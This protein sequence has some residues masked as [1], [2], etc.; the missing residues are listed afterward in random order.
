MTQPSRAPLAPRTLAP[1]LL[2]AASGWLAGCG[3]SGGSADPPVTP[4]PSV[5]LPAFS[6]PERVILAAVGEALAPQTPTATGTGSLDGFSLEGDLPAGVVF[7]SASGTFSGTPGDLAAP[8]SLRV[9][10][11]NADGSFT[12]ELSLAVSGPLRFAYSANLGD[13]TLSELWSEDGAGSLEHD[14]YTPQTPAEAAPGDVQAD[15]FGRL[16]YALNTFAITPY[17]VDPVTGDLTAGTPE[18][19]GSGPHSLYVH[20]S[21]DY[22][23]VASGAADRLRAYAVDASTG[24]L[25]LLE[26]ETT[27]VGP[28]DLAGDANGRFVIVGHETGEELKSYLIDASTGLL[29][30]A[31]SEALVT[32]ISPDIE[33]GPLGE[34]LYVVLSAPFEGVLRVNVDTATGALSLGP[35]TTAGSGPSR[36]VMAPDRRHAYVLNSGSADITYY[37]VAAENGKLTELGTLPST[38]TTVSLRF[39]K[40]G[41]VAAAVDPDEREARLYTREADGTLT[42]TGSVLLRELPQSLAF[43]EGASRVTRVMDTLYALNGDSDDITVFRVDAQLGTIDDGGLPTVPT[44][45]GPADLAIDPTGAWAFASNGSAQTVTVYAVQPNGDLVDNGTLLDLSSSNP[46]PAELVVDPSGR[47]LYVALE[48]FDILGMYAIQPDG[49]LALIGTRPIDVVPEA[50]VCDPAGLYLYVVQGGDGGAANGSFRQFAIDA[51]SG[52]LSLVSPD[53][54]AT[55]H[56]M[57]LEFTAGGARAYAAHRGIDLAVGWE[58]KA[59]GRMQ[60]IG[61]GSSTQNEPVDVAV[62]PDERFAFVAVEDS[63]AQGALL[64][65][66]VDPANGRLY[67][68]TTGQATWRN[69]IGAGLNPVA[70]EV[71]PDGR[72]LYSLGQTSEDVRVF[73]IDPDTA[74][75]AEVQVMSRGLRPLELRRRDQLQ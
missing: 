7:N 57:N 46:G 44:G 42:Q 69:A 6:Y 49:S 33:L 28:T 60:A 64:L 52:V 19:L 51:Q 18:S 38:A 63:S 61:A 71:S 45:A 13:N 3:S 37:E 55:G 66:D 62:T 2:L 9:T 8:R 59:N 15:P 23:Y 53:I 36:L 1:L 40:D 54:V 10:A 43:V 75:L 58:V 50:L 74:F 72:F 11:T 65:Y 32:V 20:P 30:L 16:V 39:S 25:T 29:T 35:T 31:D 4:P 34:S 21:G 26:Q 47:F 24:V 68:S 70:V 5:D 17:L 41:S 27:G 22:V 14:G 12:Q 73:S 48:T 67:N 56:P